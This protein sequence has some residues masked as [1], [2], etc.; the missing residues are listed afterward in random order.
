MKTLD[1]M[2]KVPMNRF[3]IILLLVCILPLVKSCISIDKN[4][5]LGKLI[6][7]EFVASFTNQDPTKTE[8]HDKTSVWWSPGDS[9]NV[10]CDDG[11][12]GVCQ[13]TNND[14]EAT[15]TFR[16]TLD[17][18]GGLDKVNSFWAVYPYDVSNTFD[19]SS[20]MM[21]VPVSQ[22]AQEDSFAPG[23]FPSVAKSSS[24]ELQFFHI[25]GGIVFTVESEGIN[26]IS[27]RGNNGEYLAG[28]VSITLDNSGIPSVKS[29]ISGETTITLTAPNSGTFTP[30]RQYYATILPGELSNGYS[31]DYERDND[32]CRRETN[33]KVTINRSRFRV[34]DFTDLEY[35]YVPYGN[36][37]FVDNN[38]K[39]KLVAKFDTNKDGELSYAEAS[40]VSSISGVF[41]K[42]DVDYTSFDEFRFF[43][44]VKQVPDSYFKNWT[45]LKSIVLPDRLES[46]GKQ[47]FYNCSSLESITF[48][49]TITEYGSSL[50][51]GC[52]K[53]V[54]IYSSNASDDNRCL[55]VN[56][57][58]KA[59]A[60][61]GIREYVLPSLVQ[62]IDKDAL[63]GC[64]QLLK[65]TI[66]SSV[67]SI[68][69]SSI[70]SKNLRRVYI[71]SETPPE[72]GNS[73]FGN[74]NV[75]IFVP[76]KSVSTYQKTAYWDKYYYR[77][78]C[79]VPTPDYVE[80]GNVRWA[81]CNLGASKPEEF[82]NYY[83]WGE[84][85]TK[86]D[87]T[88]DNYSYW[89]GKT[90]TKY[91]AYDDKLDP[92]DDVAT[93]L[94]NGEWK[95]P[96]YSQF[97]T[98]IQYA[99]WEWTENYHNTGVKGMVAYSP[100]QEK[101]ELLFFPAAGGWDGKQY[102]GS[103]TAGAYWSENKNYKNNVLNFNIVTTDNATSLLFRK[104][105][106]GYF[107]HPQYVNV[108]NADYHR[109][110]GYSI[111]PVYV[112]SKVY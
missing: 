43:L 34:L 47:A 85:A 61:Y 94:L 12:S 37:E 76:K 91:G 105:L 99:N 97:S 96:T 80:I 111:R 36:I 9:I 42:D 87:Y 27:I 77:I 107:R 6:E 16:G 14:P 15:V 83:S 71:E 29:I 50:L 84:I 33:T 1:M 24:M 41:G 88:I 21:M 82:G 90:M 17:S 66:P 40:A 18:P 26:R 28:K 79:E 5:E 11:S 10:F 110:Y 48:P 74:N 20:I 3:I 93:I 13:S 98:L 30:Q 8:V 53:L 95:M 75:A 112:G 78:V 100:G 56:N 92:S 23:M 64:D 68:A 63:S 72:A 39:A 101:Q 67:T 4:V 22:V 104:D 38:L 35:E 70:N 89:N 19:G 31:I 59:F 49:E 2:N 106:A 51:F 102:V 103:N 25:C 73:I 62:T 7:I 58:L 86:G 32:I 57:Q 108:L 52:E 55:I 109:R 81:T 60:P 69:A 46:I 54:S 45:S 65:L 44:N